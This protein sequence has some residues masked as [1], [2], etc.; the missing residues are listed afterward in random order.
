MW[1]LS[2]LHLEFTEWQ[3]SHEAISRRYDRRQVL[4]SRREIG[5]VH[6]S[7]HAADAE[8]L[9]VGIIESYEGAAVHYNAEEVNV[10]VFL[11]NF[12]AS[13]EESYTRSTP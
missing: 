6:L 1:T 9:H 13:K 5:S 2:R 10:V 3:H 11:A 12:I 8:R 4:L 7:N